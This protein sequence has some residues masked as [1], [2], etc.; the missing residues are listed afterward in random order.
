MKAGQ[1]VV[2]NPQGKKGFPIPVTW[3]ACDTVRVQADSLEEAYEWVQEHSDEIPL[4]TEPGYVDGSYKIGD[5]DECEAYLDEAV[6]YLGVKEV[7]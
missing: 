5:F 2:A 4:G 6:D 7:S 3:E 1:T